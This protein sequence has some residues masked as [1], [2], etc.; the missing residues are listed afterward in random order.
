VVAVSLP[1]AAADPRSQGAQHEPAGADHEERLIA[2]VPHE[3]PRLHAAD[4]PEDDGS[5]GDDRDS[6]GANS[7]TASITLDCS[8][9]ESP[10][11][12]GSLTRHSATASVTG[13][14]PHSGSRRRPIGEV[15]S[16][17]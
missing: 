5:D 7:V 1:G 17:A 15:C 9:S 10:A 6:Y 3:L 12:S 14:G 16:G 2:E 11:Y 13:S 4:Q 8:S